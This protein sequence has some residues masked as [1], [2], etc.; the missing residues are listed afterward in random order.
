MDPPP[1][2]AL[3]RASHFPPTVAVTAMATALAVAVGR[4][5][6]GTLAVLLAVLAGQL[7]VGWSNDY[8]DRDR[9]R[10]T[11]RAD[12]PIVSGAVAA[13]TVGLAA[14]GAAAACVPLSLLSGW[15]AALVHLG[16]VAL[17][18]GYNAGL[19]NTI[20]SVV[21]YVVAFGALPVF[22]TLGLPGHPLPPG[23]AIAAAALLGGGAH[24]VN[25]LPDLDDDARV[26]IRGLPHRCGPRASLAIAAVLLGSA[27]A[28]LTFAP[29]G[30][31]DAPELALLVITLVA[32]LG[33][34]VAG[35]VGL[36]RVAW[37]LTLGVAGL[38]VVLFLAHGSALA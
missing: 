20:W 8:L 17:A 23:W 14:I 35:S 16:A 38:G 3:A 6:D 5:V 34:V 4:G 11:G 28:I 31:P 21:P 32:V 26:G 9:D 1:V 30:T 7:S 18:W 15:R 13:R 33:V 19:K 12:K 36:A 25:T 24:F 37:Y 2:V 10:R 27:A 22:V 29:P